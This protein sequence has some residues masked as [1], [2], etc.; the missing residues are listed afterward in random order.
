MPS[1]SKVDLLIK[2]DLVLSDRV[3]ANTYVGV[4]SGSIVGIYTEE[5]LPEAKEFIDA[6]GKIVFPGV[7]DAHV[8]SYSNLQERFEHSTAAAAAGGVT[9]IIEMPYDSCGPV[10]DTNAYTEKQKWIADEAKVDVA[11]LSTIK[12]QGDLESVDALVELGTCGF[13]LSAFETCPERFPRIDDNVLWDILPTLAKT[14]LPVGFHAENDIIIEAL[15]ARYK[16]EGMTYPKA[17]CETRPPISETLA[18][19]KLLEFA[20]WTKFSLHIYHSSHP[21]C[22]D[23][24]DWYRDQGV[25]VSVET[26]PH[27]LLLS[28]DDMPEKKAFAKINPPM[29]SQEAVSGLWQGLFDGRID[30]IASD[31]APWPLERKSNEAIFNNGSGAPGVESMLP[32]MFSEAVVKRDMD[33]VK[34]GQLLA[35]KPA[36]RFKLSH[37]K[38][39]IA[40]GKDADFAI[41]DPNH[42]WYFDASVT[43]SSAKWSPYEGKKVTGKVTQTILRGKTIYADDVVLAKA[44]DGQYVAA[45]K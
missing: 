17:H 15:I 29:R 26:C 22:L 41:I 5:S 42:E 6:T 37:R 39:S 19:S 7:V 27:Y 11:L 3:A 36:T 23:M 31:H 44:G 13:K 10:F 16:A 43:Q 21:R 33:I 1:S 40:V 8:H 14:D 35:L 18:V 34:L 28:E 24:I 25:D 20:Y 30:W 45:Q 38:G 32:L 9:T 4:C 12:K 2:G